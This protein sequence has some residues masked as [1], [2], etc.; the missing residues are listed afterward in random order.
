MKQLS[1]YLRSLQGFLQAAPQ[2]VLQLVILFKGVYIH[3]LHNSIEV[4][5]ESEYDFQVLKEY[6]S[7]KPLGWYWGLIQVYSLIF[8]FLSLLQTCVQFN[9]W[10]KRRHTLHRMLLVVPFFGITIIYRT[11]AIAVL[12]C[13]S[14]AKLTLMPLAAIIISQVI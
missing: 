8:S 10:E 5:I 9:E 6:M 14:G 2:L 4:F 13:L 7:H 12:I 1:V 11:M 3:S